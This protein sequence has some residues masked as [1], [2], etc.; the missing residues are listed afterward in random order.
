MPSQSVT[1]ESSR[2]GPLPKST[3]FYNVYNIQRTLGLRIFVNYSQFRLKTWLPYKSKHP[4][5]GY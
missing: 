2:F 5:Y 1:I 4:V 3:I